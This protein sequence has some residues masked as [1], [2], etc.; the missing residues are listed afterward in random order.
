MRI[1]FEVRGSNLCLWSHGKFGKMSSTK[2]LKNKSRRASINFNDILS[3][4]PAR[5]LKME[6][7]PVCSKENVCR[8]EK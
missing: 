5:S 2:Y 1:F 4:T 7:I 3:E 6:N 8:G